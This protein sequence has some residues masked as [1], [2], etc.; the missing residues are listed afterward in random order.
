MSLVQIFDAPNSEDSIIGEIVN[1]YT[2]PRGAEMLEV[3]VDHDLRL[4]G[5]SRM[6]KV[7]S[8]PVEKKSGNWNGRIVNL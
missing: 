4:E 1:K 2:T 6:G 5:E 8:V 3:F 7:I